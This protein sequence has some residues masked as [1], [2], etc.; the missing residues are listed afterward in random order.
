MIYL[1]GGAP[2]TGKS[3][4]AQ[5]MAGGLQAGWVSTD[6]LLELLRVKNAEAIKTQWDASVEAIR[7]AAEWFFP[8]LE[9]FVWGASSMAD[10]YV[11]EGVDFLPEQVMQLSRQYPVRS[12]FLGCSDMTLERFD[13]SPGRSPGYI[14]LPESMRRQMAQDVPR[15]SEFIRRGCERFGYPYVDV[16]GDFIQRLHAAE[17]AL[18]A[19]V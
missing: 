1:V 2:R 4:L 11:I 14:R 16:A 7:A 12:V 5:R 8:Y 6:L 13:L 17:A 18:T 15:W 10:N 19:G 9:R 3:I